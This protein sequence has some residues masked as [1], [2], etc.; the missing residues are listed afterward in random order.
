MKRYSLSEE[1]KIYL[2]FGSRD[3]KADASFDRLKCH[4]P[5]EGRRMVL[6]RE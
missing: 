5:E 2:V 6:T 4:V 1:M 3:V